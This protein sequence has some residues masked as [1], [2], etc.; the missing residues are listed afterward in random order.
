MSSIFGNPHV[1]SE[2]RPWKPK[3]T[4]C[5]LRTEAVFPSAV[6]GVSGADG[7]NCSRDYRSGTVSLYM[8]LKL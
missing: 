4:H 7:T 5:H 3:P 2:S 8:V 6:W 1:E